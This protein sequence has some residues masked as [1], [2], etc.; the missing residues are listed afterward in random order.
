MPSGNP[1]RRAATI[2]AT[3][4]EAQAAALAQVQAKAR[5][6][7]LDPD[8]VKF[9]E[10]WQYTVRFYIARFDLP[11][12]DPDTGKP[13]KSFRPLSRNISGWSVADLQGLLP[14]YGIDK[15]PPTGPVFF[16]EGERKV[17]ALR[18]IGLHAV[19]SAHGAKSP[20]KSD[21]RPLK[22]REAIGLPDNDDSGTKYIDKVGRIVTRL[23]PPATVSVLTLP[24]LPPKGDVVDFLGPDGPMDGKTADQC[25]ERILELAKNAT[26]WATLA[27]TI[28]GDWPEPR[29]LPSELPPVLAFDYN[30]LPEALRPWIQDIAE[31]T[32]CPPD[33]PAVGV[34]VALAGIVGRKIAIRPKKHD[35]WTVVP[36]V[37]GAVIG[38]P[39][40]MK[41]PAL[42]QPLRPL[43]RLEIEAKERFDQEAKEY[44]AAKLV[45]DLTRKER[46][47]EVRK[48][49]RDG[50]DALA[51]ATEILSEETSGPVRRRYLVN[52]SSVEKLGELL[53]ENSNGLTVYRDEL[54]G[55]LRSL[56]REGQESARAFYLEAWDGAGRFTYDRIGRGTIDIEAATV[57]IIGG[58]QPGRLAEYL[59]AAVKGGEDDD[60]LIQRFQL[61]VWPDVDSQWRNVDRWPD[62]QV[63]DRAY[64][65]F[66]RLNSL[67]PLAA[68][69]EQDPQDP[70]A[71]P[72]LRFASEA[73]D[74]FD[75]WR[76]GLEKKIR[77]GDEHPAMESHLAKYRSLIPSLALLFHLADGEIGPVGT[78]ALGRAIRW[79]EYLES[80]A[81]RM[82]ALAVN[83][84]L[85]AGK[86]LSQRILAGEVPACFALRDLYRNGW[87]GLSD[88]D[89]AER[90]ISLL[91]DLDWLHQTVETTS[92]RDRRRFF[93]NPKVMKDAP[94]AN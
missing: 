90:A 37:W 72:F 94:R 51:I 50:G 41:T 17:D 26:P 15:L 44:E 56:D 78:L 23:S 42:R 61:A 19:T 12:T 93:V 59:R 16:C 83:S 33:F 77:C 68:N 34:T 21:W 10:R 79:G 25:R 63:R 67:N 64:E 84:D 57:S 13:R 18:K 73:Q 81:R 36:N 48:A 45:A 43:Q 88:R 86:A 7:G 76:A 91:L 39:G 40:I 71:I 28:A 2:Y 53:N 3:L 85:A 69:A 31:R 66:A 9:S 29:P 58:I 14:L 65:V 54:V 38:R 20:E 35:D 75:G 30:L 8:G 5:D 60:G 74:T 89:D 47:G 24:D 92:G 49:I 55:L 4:D 87:S 46:E 80:H 82:Y 62:T 1:K 11:E 6:D 52:D 27:P 32:Q 70:Q 22:G